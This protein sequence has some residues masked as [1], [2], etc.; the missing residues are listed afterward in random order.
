VE[1]LGK[2]VHSLAI[3]C[4]HSHRQSKA[5]ADSRDGFGKAA[6]AVAH[7]IAV[8]WYYVVVSCERTMDPAVV[9]SRKE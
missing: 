1:G 6:E 8:G 2:V 7:R 5:V 3:R 4:Q 9:G